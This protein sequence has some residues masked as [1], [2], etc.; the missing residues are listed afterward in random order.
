[1]PFSRSQRSDLALLLV[2]FIWGINFPI[3]KLALE[4]MPPYVVNAFRFAVSAVVLG[5]IHGWRTRHEPG[6]FLAPIREHGRTVVGLGMLG[7]V[8]YQW[9]FIVGIDA[10]SAGSGALIISSSPV[11]TAVIAR[12]IGMERLPFGAWGGLALSLAG[13]ALVILAGHASPDFANDTLFGNGL[14]LLGAI[15]W[16]AYT[17]FSRPVLKAGVSA[18]G[19]AFFGILVSLPVLWGLGLS[20]IGLVDWAAVDGTVWLAL[21]FSGGLSTGLAYALW[22]TAVQRVGP[23]QTAIYNNLV[24][25][26]ALSSG[27]VLIGEPVTVYQLLGGALILGGLFLMRRARR[28]VA[29]V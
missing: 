29:L 23:S 4:P 9:C 14:M 1:M 18:T 16:A 26:V 8:C 7:Y 10:T 25:V 15:L 21:L 5:S 22:N 11:W 12:A 3:I 28:R 24:P 17:V 19:L 27:V 20:E 13:T 6:G 2:V